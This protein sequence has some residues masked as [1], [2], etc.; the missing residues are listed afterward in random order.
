MQS[1][2]AERHRA[3]ITQLLGSDHAYKDTDDRGTCIRFRIPEGLRGF[4]DAVLGRIEGEQADDFVIGRSD[5]APTFHLA[6]VIDDHDMGITHIVYVSSVTALYDPKANVLNE[7][8]PPGTANN[9]YGKSKVECEIYVRALQDRGASIH[10]TYP[11]SVIGPDDPALTN[12]HRGLKTYLLGVAPVMSGGTQWV[13][14][15]Y[16]TMQSR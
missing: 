15:R 13:D 8:S 5:G 3:V 1:A 10:I 12:P 16:P 4:D 7:L 14:V 2:N 11:S 9:T 6:N